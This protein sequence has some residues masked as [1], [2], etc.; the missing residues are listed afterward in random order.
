MKRFLMVCMFIV[1]STL[2]Y[3]EKVMRVG[4]GVPESHFEYKG[5][6]LFKKNLEEKQTKR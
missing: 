3:A 4:L 5:M 6:E 1:L 2:G